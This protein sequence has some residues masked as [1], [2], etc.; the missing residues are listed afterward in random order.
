MAQL[1]SWRPY[2]GCKIF[3]EQLEFYRIPFAELLSAL[4]D[5]PVI[6]LYRKNM[7]D[8]YISLQVAFKT[9][10]W[11]SQEE[12]NECSSVEV[13][14]DEYKHYAETERQRWKET[15]SA[16]A[17]RGRRKVYFLSYEELIENKE[18][19][20]LGIFSFLNLPPC[21]TIAY[22]VRQNPF[23]VAQKVSNFSDVREKLGTFRGNILNR[24]WMEGCVNAT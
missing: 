3:C 18:E 11:F 22:S 2:S 20:L 6:V 24:D 21:E 13:N 15:L 4:R 9:G 7:L 14:F 17:R 12:N 1:L 19:S 23:S 8:T 16:F 10:V 5:P